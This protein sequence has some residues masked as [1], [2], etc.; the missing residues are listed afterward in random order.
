MESGSEGERE[1][2]SANVF[3]RKT[4][5]ERASEQKTS[6]EMEVGIERCWA[7][8]SLGSGLDLL[9]SEL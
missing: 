5:S 3:A 1:R 7:L 6:R 9:H 4:Q 2:G 8:H